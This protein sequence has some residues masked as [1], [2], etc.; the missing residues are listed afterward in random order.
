MDSGFEEHNSSFKLSLSLMGF[1]HQPC[2][3]FWTPLQISSANCRFGRWHMGLWG[4]SIGGVCP[5]YFMYF[6]IMKD[7]E[8]ENHELLMLH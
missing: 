4:N 6:C 8:F 5:N 2:N 1:W 3:D 7:H